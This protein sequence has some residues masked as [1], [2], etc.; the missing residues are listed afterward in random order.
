MLNQLAQALTLLNHSLA[1]NNGLWLEFPESCAL[2]H[3]AELR[4][5]TNALRV[6]GCQIGLEHVGLEFTK[7]RELQDIGL[8]YLKIDGAI[9]R[10]IHKDTGNQKFLSGLCKIGHSLGM[11]MIAEG[12]HSQEEKEKLLQLDVDG[13]TGPGI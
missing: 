4:S 6:L 12:V 7:I 10:D 2:R 11:L 1:K 9:V 3:M 8:H 5:F 13:L